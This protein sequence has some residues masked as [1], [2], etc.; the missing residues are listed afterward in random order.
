M[1]ILR[2]GGVLL[3]FGGLAVI[4]LT[5]YGILS[6]GDKTPEA[7][8]QRVVDQLAEGDAEVIW[9]SLPPSY[10]RDINDLVHEFAARM[11]A[12]IWDSSFRVLQ[13]TTRVLQEKKDFILGN[14][15][16]A[17]NPASEGAAEHWDQIVDFFS[18]IAHSEF[19]S[20]DEMK[21]MD[22]GV[23]L[24]GT[25]SRLLAQAAALS[26]LAPDQQSPADRLRSI[27]IA[28]VDE[29]EGSSTLAIKA[30]GREQQEM[31][32]IRFEGKW[33]PAPMV[34]SWN[35]AIDAAR[36]QIKTIDSERNDA[37]RKKALEMLEM[38]ESALDR[39]LAAESQD[40]FDQSLQQIVPLVMGAMMA[41]A[42]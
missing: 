39:L 35:D 40:D 26:Q 25:G 30:P 32:W 12:P 21:S 7:V 41:A 29:A 27:S 18:T 36:D 23:F 28:V 33:L 14:P 5:Q 3:V 4:G 1:S 19:S 31:L 8:L 42:S 9:D 24:G 2:A 38:A 16:I 17:A 20:L 15:A 37:A 22:V 11:D 10:Q 13:K 6:S 34:D